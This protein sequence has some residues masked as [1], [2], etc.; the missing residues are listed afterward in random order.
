MRTVGGVLGLDRQVEVRGR[1]LTVRGAGTPVT[2]SL[3]EQEARR[4]SDAA[5]RL[6][7]LPDVPLQG[8][9]DVADSGWTE[10]RVVLDGTTRTLRVPVAADAPDEVWDLLGAVDDLVG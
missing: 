9:A 4:L 5:A 7:A 3:E 6:L 8:P 10:L 2:R 1:E